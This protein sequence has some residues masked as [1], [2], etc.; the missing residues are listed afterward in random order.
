LRTSQAPSL[1]L[2]TMPE[3]GAL[4]QPAPRSPEPRTHL[5]ER[6]NGRLAVLLAAAALMALAAIAPAQV[7]YDLERAE[8]NELE[9]LQLG[10]GRF[11]S[12]EFAVYTGELVAVSGLPG[13]ERRTLPRGA[14]VAALRKH[15]RLAGRS[16]SGLTLTVASAGGERWIRLSQAASEPGVT[17]TNRPRSRSSSGGVTAS[18][19]RCLVDLSRQPESIEL[20]RLTFHGKLS[21]RL[22]SDFRVELSGHLERV[23]ATDVD[24]SQIEVLEVALEPELRGE[25]AGFSRSD[26]EATR[27]VERELRERLRPPAGGPSRRRCDRVTRYSAE[28]FVDLSYP[29][30][31][32]VRGIEILGT[33]IC[34]LDVDAH[35]EDAR[36]TLEEPR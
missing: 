11:A 31:F 15:D 13:S 21:D 24:F 4:R 1:R 17:R 16:G 2:D 19:R 22:A 23:P 18:C 34:C 5:S 14:V 3:A 10:I 26:G 29:G 33:E 7:S 8:Q 25:L 20:D 30:R 27:R 12:G 28:R 6:A 35:G 36:C 32:G 9:R